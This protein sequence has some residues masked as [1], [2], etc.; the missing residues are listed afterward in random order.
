MNNNMTEQKI[1]QYSKMSKA[2]MNIPID[3]DRI[4]GNYGWHEKFPYERYLLTRPNKETETVVKTD[5]SKLAIDFGCGPGRMVN[6]MS[7]FF[8]RV[9]GIDVSAYALEVAKKKFPTNNF[10]E[11][12]GSD[13]GETPDNTYDFVYNTISIQHIPCRTIRRRIYE[14]LYKCLKPGGAISSQLAYNPTY[15][16]GVWS[17]DT[18]HASYESDFFDA[19]KTNGHA[20]CVINANDLPMVKE[21]FESYGFKDVEFRLVDVASLYPNLEGEYHAPYWASHWLFV[22]GK[23]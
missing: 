11:S 14:G 8:E 9:D 22:Y 10:Y 19:E 3:P 5:K 13:C 7:K 6:R 23:K 17:N 16:A 4:V 2:F 15:V 20:D 1:E 12:S 21:D 18:V